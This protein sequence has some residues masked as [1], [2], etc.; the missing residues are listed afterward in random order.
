MASVKT[1]SI[2]FL[3]PYSKTSVETTTTEITFNDELRENA[4]AYGSHNRN[5]LAAYTKQTTA[6]I[7]AILQMADSLHASP[8]CVTPKKSRMHA[9]CS[10]STCKLTNLPKGQ[11]AESELISLTS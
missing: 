1:S 3:I 4:D 7:N 5:K 10:R 6:V 8:N 11:I 2:L 9:E